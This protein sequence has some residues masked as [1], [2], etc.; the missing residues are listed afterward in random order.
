MT[1]LLATPD[2]DVWRTGYHAFYFV[3][4]FVLQQ[5]EML[6]DIWIMNMQRRI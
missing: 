3:V 1:P 4:A 2:A 5:G 6:L